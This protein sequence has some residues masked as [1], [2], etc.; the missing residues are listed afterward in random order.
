MT[1]KAWKPKRVSGGPSDASSREYVVE[2]RARQKM[3]RLEKEPREGRKWGNRSEPV[4]EYPRELGRAVM[5]I[6]ASVFMEVT[7]KVLCRSLREVMRLQV[8]ARSGVPP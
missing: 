8:P 2:V 6:Q 5:G 7:M 1:D 3:E 4:F